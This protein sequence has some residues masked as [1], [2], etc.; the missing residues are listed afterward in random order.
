MRLI[1]ITIPL[2]NV[3]W[4]Y[5]IHV[6][7]FVYVYYID[8]FLFKLIYCTILLCKE[9]ITNRR[10]IVEQLNDTKCVSNRTKSRKIVY[11]NVNTFAEK[12]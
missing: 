2:A 11:K 6:H 10:R 1:I 3:E 9:S 5:E 4:R 12:M 8:R 7:I